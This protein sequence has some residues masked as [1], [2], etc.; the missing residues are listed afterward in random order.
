MQ[1]LLS[2]RLHRLFFSQLIDGLEQ[3]KTHSKR[4]ANECIKS[5]GQ[6]KTQ[7]V[8]RILLEDGDAVSKQ[9]FELPELVSEGSLLVVAG[10]GSCF[11]PI[12]T[13]S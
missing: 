7:N 9:H 10:M 8:F 5:N 4:L 2:A 13:E 12:I 6:A 11:H 3:Y 1:R